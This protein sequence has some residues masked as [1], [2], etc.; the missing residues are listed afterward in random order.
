MRRLSLTFI[1]GVLV[2]IPIAGTIYLLN[3]LYRLLND[4]GL[5]LLNKIPIPWHFP[6]IGILFVVGFVLVVGFCAR[7]WVIKK[8]LTLMESLIEKI[9]LIKGIYGTLKDTIHSFIGEKNSFDTVVFVNIGESKRMGFLTVKKPAFRTKDGKE[10][11]GVYFPQSYQLAGDLYWY[12]RE[13]IEI[14]DLPVDEALRLILSGGI[15]G[16]HK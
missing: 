4:L 6:G 13:Q 11:V 3:Y 1:N 16:N 5:H 7:M 9:P 14:L 8:F 15:A 2:L 12:E 10:Y